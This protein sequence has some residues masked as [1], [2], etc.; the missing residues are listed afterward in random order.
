MPSRAKRKRYRQRLAKATANAPKT[1]GGWGQGLPVTRSD[2]RLLRHAIR[3]G[4]TD[5]LPQQMRDLIVSD[6][7]K[8]ITTD[9]GWEDEPRKQIA[10]T[11]AI[12]EMVADNARC[13]LRD[14]EP[15]RW[16]REC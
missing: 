1:A 10:A 9:E 7:T 6:V 4:W 13:A 11:L 3:E 15:L 16:G 8:I 14:F 12:I 5:D 2:L